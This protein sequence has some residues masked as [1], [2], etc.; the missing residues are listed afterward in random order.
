MATG[1]RTRL[2]AVL[3]FALLGCDL[4][5]EPPFP[6]SG[7]PFAPPA[8]YALWWSMVEACAGRSGDMTQI[9]W[10]TL[11]GQS[12]LR[13]WGETFHGYTWNDPDRILL[14][15]GVMHDGG[16]IRHEMLHALL[17]PG[18]HPRAF[19]RDRCGAIVVCRG[20]CA[21]ETRVADPPVAAP[22]VSAVELV[23]SVRV[24]P[25][26]PSASVHDGWFVLI[27]EATNPRSQAVWV[28]LEPTGSG[29]AYRKTFGFAVGPDFKHTY[30]FSDSL[31]VGFLAGE[32]KQS[33][34]DIHATGTSWL[35]G[36]QAVRGVFSN[37]ISQPVIVR[38][39]P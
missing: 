16:L 32:T 25:A 30:E 24:V 21:D 5:T 28:D 34:F 1:V 17:G 10:Y 18:G 27:V 11:P 39:V 8:Q 13:V 35:D 23:V 29:S 4:A 7:V 37:A 14:A 6:A 38:V 15:D 9:A 33:A 3:L 22:T 31:R 19:F 26:Q 12:A 36:E 2:R 20:R